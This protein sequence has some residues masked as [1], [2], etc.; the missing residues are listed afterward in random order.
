MAQPP[1]PAPE[2]PVLNEKLLLFILA[3]VQFTHILDFMIIMPLGSQFMRIFDISPRQFSLI[4]SAY[5]GSAFVMG[6]FS[7]M[8]IDRFGRKQALFFTYIGFTIGTIA[9][10]MAP[11][12]YFFL[13]ARSIT[14][15][16]GGILGA[17]VLSII[18][19]TIPL[20]RRASAMGTVMTAFSVASVLGVPAGIYLAAEFSWRAP[21]LAV[22][23]MAVALAFGIFFFMPPLRA[24][25]ES[26]LVQRNP[27]RVMGNIFGDANQR[28]ALLF[29]VI[30]MLGHFTIIPFIAPYMQLNIGFS[31]Y[32]VTYIYFIG[33]MLTVF[34][35]PFFGRLADRHGHAKVFTVSSLFAL[36]SIFA[37]TN[38]P[39]VSIV[40][41]LCATSSFFVVASGRNVP[42]MTMVTSVVQP[43]SRGSF[44][45]V[46]SS[47]QEMA[48]AL[49]SLVAGLII[50]ENG[51]GSLGN[52]QYVGY[53]AIVMSLVAVALAWRLKLA[54][55]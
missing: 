40:L 28:L 34:L 51:D 52:Y 22:G 30:L 17:L 33:G 6:L 42:A 47:V 41:A 54:D 12:Y 53:I 27:F 37:I 20:K 13:A 43:E 3:M 2:P 38:L 55:G 4:V 5:A 23:G 36:F 48:L 1:I 18:G 49:S 15:A 46:R 31:D 39:A 8:F 44:M 21:F 11:G 26:G 45:S 25:L 19:D 29:T 16:F 35:L 7:A 32:Q 14:G 10:A 24:H 50:T 9:C